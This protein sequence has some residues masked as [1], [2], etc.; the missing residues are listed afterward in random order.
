MK[1]RNN[2]FLNENLYLLN[3]FDIIKWWFIL[4]IFEISFKEKEMI[5]KSIRLKK[6]YILN[7]VLYL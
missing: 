3:K 7:I 2:Y 5:L 1:R 4:I 6:K